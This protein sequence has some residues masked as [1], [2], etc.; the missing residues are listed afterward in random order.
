MKNRYYLLIP[1]TMLLLFGLLVI[2]AKAAS[3]SDPEGDVIGIQTW[4]EGGNPKIDCDWTPENTSMLDIESI[5]WLDAGLNYTVSMTFYGNVNQTLIEDSDVIIGMFFLINGSSFPD[6]LDSETPE[7]HITI[8][9]EGNGTILGNETSIPIT[10]VMVI[11]GDTLTWNFNKSI[12]DVTPVV[13][14][15]W[16][17]IAYATYTYT[18]GN[19]TNYALDH[20][21]FDYLEDTLTTVCNLLNLQIPGYSLIAVGVVA[22]TTIG[23]I[24]RKKFKK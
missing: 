9:S 8:T 18:D 21:N 14:E 23:L 7:A 19:F 22:V 17:L 5:E 10:N 24:I 2:P 20:Y 3:V 6:E 4:T 11:S 13:L 1:I 12:T 15:N 16:D